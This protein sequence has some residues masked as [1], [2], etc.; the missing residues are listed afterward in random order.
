MKITETKIKGLKI[1]NGLKFSDDRGYFR[2]IFKNKIIKKQDLI[3][4]CMSTSKK[5]VLRGLHLQHQNSQGKFVSVVKGKIL[6]VAVDCRYNSKTFG[7]HFKIILSENNCKALFIPAGFAHG[8]LSLSKENTVFYGCSNYRSAKSELTINWLDP[9]IKIKWPKNKKIIS[10][11]DKVGISLK[12]Y[13]KLLLK[14]NST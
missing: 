10:K 6:D 8:F 3:F 13:K 11:K 12:D 14:K 2:E 7:K 9:D 4:W 5:D 1:I